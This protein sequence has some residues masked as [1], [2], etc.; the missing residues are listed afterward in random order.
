MQRL[1]N[2]FNPTASVAMIYM[3][4]K[5][6]TWKWNTG[7]LHHNQACHQLCYHRQYENATPYDDLKFSK[8]SENKTVFPK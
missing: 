5:K 6:T 8:E 7:Q 3:V 4:I 2:K 1:K